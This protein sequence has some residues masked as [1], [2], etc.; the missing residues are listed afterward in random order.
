MLG[1]WK[2]LCPELSSNKTPRAKSK[3]VWIIGAWNLDIVCYLLIGAWNFLD[4]R[5]K[6]FL[7][8]QVDF[9]NELVGYMAKAWPQPLS[10]YLSLTF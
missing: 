7:D 5:T 10:T 6:L 1:M 9:I 3:P 2:A 8:I 4:S